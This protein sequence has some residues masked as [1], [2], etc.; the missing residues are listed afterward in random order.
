MIG[1]SQDVKSNKVHLALIKL[2]HLKELFEMNRF[3][4]DKSMKHYHLGSNSI[5]VIDDAIKII[6][7][8]TNLVSG[9]INGRE[10]TN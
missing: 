4:R 3:M 9:F 6:G 1:G 2:R 10:I 8:K 7:Y 5:K